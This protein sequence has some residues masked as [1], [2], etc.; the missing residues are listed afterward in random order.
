MIDPQAKED[1][2][3]AD[4]QLVVGTSLWKDAF[5]RL[6][7]NKAAMAGLLVVA[8]MAI[9]A[10]AY[11]VISSSIT[12]FS[13]DEQHL[14]VVPKP[15]GARS[16]PSTYYKMMPPEGDLAFEKVDR[17]GDGFITEQEIEEAYRRY[18]FAQVDTDG[19]GF[20]TYEEYVNAP[21][22]LAP[23]EFIP[24][25]AKWKIAKKSMAPPENRYVFECDANEDGLMAYENAGKLVA[26]V[27]ASEA[28]NILNRFDADHDLGLN[29]QEYI[30]LPRPEIN[31]L[32]T[33]KLGRD[34][35]TRLVYG[36]RISL[37]VGL[38][39]T[40]VS[41]LIGVSWGATAGFLGGKVDNI[42][43]RI[44]DVMYG[45]PFMILIILLVSVFGSDIVILFVALGAIQWLTMA[46]IVRGQV[47]SLKE[48]EFVEA[49]RCIGVSTP[50]II[51]KHLIPNALGP[52]IVYT[53]LTVP[54]VM[55]E[56]AFLS[57]LGLGIQA[58][59]TSWGALA[60]EGRQIMR[61]AP[62]VILASGGAL[63]VTLMSLNFLGDGLRDALDPQIRKD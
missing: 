30:G 55:L 36:A 5:R 1:A 31:R 13:L 35:L 62:W 17:D 29:Q 47:I 23:P 33:D 14:F 4:V 59:L 19:D 63:A 52:I 18:E 12:R 21:L 49:A 53:T 16:V 3:G 22:S 24:D 20:L 45:M 37:A 34:L 25:C 6:R 7:K 28:R 2:G 44:V 50:G 8:F 38:L 56:E 61:T 41:L 43:M 57:F 10:L 32:G 39:A 9:C 26:L 27:S 15:P 11:P 40:L 51:F 58:P 54:A 42:M 48:Q 60:S 46:R